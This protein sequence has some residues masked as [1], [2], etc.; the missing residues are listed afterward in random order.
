MPDLIGAAQSLRQ[1]GGAMVMRVGKNGYPHPSKKSECRAFGKDGLHAGLTPAP[2]CVVLAWVS[3]DQGLCLGLLRYRPRRSSAVLPRSPR[4]GRSPHGVLRL[5][6]SAVAAAATA[7]LAA[8]R[9][10]GRADRIAGTG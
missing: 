7:Q 2:S 3:H 4:P 8:R 1:S 9:A 10:Q 6:R 5:E